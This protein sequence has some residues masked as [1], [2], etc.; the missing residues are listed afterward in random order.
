MFITA[1]AL[2]FALSNAPQDPPTHQQAVNCTGVFLFT[3]VLTA[4]AAE[5]DP[6]AENGE[7]AELAG[8]FP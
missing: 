4:Q 2:S 6:T 1:L 5:A 7:T 8:C 3:A